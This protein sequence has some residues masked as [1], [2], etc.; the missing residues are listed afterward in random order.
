ML[1]KL[2]AKIGKKIKNKLTA[3]WG[4]D[5]GAF[6]PGHFY[7]P[8]PT[9]KD[10]DERFEKLEVSLEAFR[11]IDLNIDGQLKLL[12]EF[13]S[14]FDKNPYAKEKQ[15]GS[16]YYFDNPS[17]SCF[18][19]VILQSMIRKLAPKNIIEV[20]S[21][22]SSALM[23]DVNDKFFGGKINVSFIE[24][25]ADLL[26]NNLTEEDLKRTTLYESRLQDTDL[27]IFDKLKEND[28]L[29]IDSTHV[30]RVN[31]DVQKIFSDILPRLNKGVYVHFHDIFAMFEYP[32]IW[33]DAGWYWNEAYVLRAF[34]QY[35]DTF[36]IEFF[37]EFLN[38]FFK[39][40][41]K[42]L[43]FFLEKPNYGSLWLMKLK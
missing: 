32:K 1:K 39:E 15:E 34:L 37:N 35:N 33:L 12:E 18:D 7:S 40:E 21:G 28:I 26:K 38:I 27:T 13:K 3:R 41:I 11:G 19:G 22:Y 25:Y 4:L 14:Y 8:I 5:C 43:N 24:P 36:K 29:F 10:I 17:F 20:G 30:C 16:R 23:M 42:D 6:K 31:S 9:Q 2:R